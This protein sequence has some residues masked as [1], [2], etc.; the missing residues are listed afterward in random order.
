MTNVPIGDIDASVEQIANLQADGCEIVRL[1]VPKLSDVQFFEKIKNRLRSRN[2]AMPLVA[3]VHFSPKIA[4]DC[5]S[6]AD[7][8]RI[9]AG[10]FAEKPGRTFDESRNHTMEKFSTFFEAA[11]ERGIPV[12]IGVNAG[13]LSSR[14]LEKYG[15]TA[16]GMWESAH[17]CILAARRVGFHNLVLSF[18][19]SDV[20]LMV[21]SCQLA[22]AEMDKLGFDYPL[23]LGVTEPGNRQYARIKSAIGIGSLL[24]AGIG[25]T[26]RI[27][28]T[29]DPINEIQVAR[30]ILQAIGMRRFSAE[31]VA[32]PSCGRTNYDIQCVFELVKEKIG[33]L[34]S[35]RNLKIAVMGCVVNG[36][37]EAGNADY[38]IVGMPNGSVNIYN[39]ETCLLKNIDPILAAANLEKIISSNELN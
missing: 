20:K 33:M 32:C 3:D 24:L 19:A 7:K 27:S 37:G 10:N 30:D 13:S 14:M 31:L 2:I 4:H 18:K 6:I 21:E 15:N 12:R 36:L 17:E 9:N 23:H 11:S 39:G 34:E 35:A 28:L 8:V 22:C 5:L 16:I 38:A 1:A 29:E 26:M 25:D